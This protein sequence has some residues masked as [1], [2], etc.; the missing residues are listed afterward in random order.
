MSVFLLLFLPTPKLCDIRSYLLSVNLRHP[1][2]GLQGVLS[3]LSV[4]Q[5]LFSVGLIK[6]HL[7]KQSHNLHSV[8]IV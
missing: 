7:L 2:G 6:G 8:Y 1:F 3:A 5:T 4:E